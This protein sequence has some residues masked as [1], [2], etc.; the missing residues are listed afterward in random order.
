MYGK[1]V[2]FMCLGFILYVAKFF[3][4][5]CQCWLYQLSTVASVPEYAEISA[6]KISLMLLKCHLNINVKAIPY[7]KQDR[8]VIIYAKFCH[9]HAQ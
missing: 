7:F 3:P 2:S 1:S 8:N 4:S 6:A 5:N 9:T